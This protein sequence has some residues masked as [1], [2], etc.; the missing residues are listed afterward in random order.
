MEWQPS[1][2]AAR[3]L[4][5]RTWTSG[6]LGGEGLTCSAPGWTPECERVCWLALPY[7]YWL[8]WLRWKAIWMWTKWERGCWWNWFFILDDRWDEIYR[9]ENTRARWVRVNIEANYTTVSNVM[10]NHGSYLYLFIFL[11]VQYSMLVIHQLICTS[12]DE[13]SLLLIPDYK[14]YTNRY[15][16]DGGTMGIWQSAVSNV[17]SMFLHTYYTQSAFGTCISQDIAAMHYNI[18]L[19][20]CAVLSCMKGIG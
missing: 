9:I 19:L 10:P 12:R 2:W 20:G 18:A 15:S 14:H 7:W 5:P 16:D 11:R 1:W 3:R 13:K 8:H 4:E 17:C 6:A